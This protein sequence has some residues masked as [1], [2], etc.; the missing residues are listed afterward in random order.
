MNTDQSKDIHIAEIQREY[1]RIDRDWL[2]LHY[3]ISIGLVLFAF[4]VECFIGV[5]VVNSDMLSTSISTYL[6]K[7]LLA[8]SLINLLAIL[9]DSLVLRSQRFSQNQKIYTV[10]LMMVFICFILFS[11]HNAF[12]ATHMIFAVA[13]L[14]TVIYAD[15][16]L[17]G[18]TAASSILALV[19]SELF[20][21]WDLDKVSVFDST[22]RF[23]D[24]LVAIFVLFAAACVCLVEIH[25]ERKKNEASILKEIERQQLRLRLQRDEMTGVYNRK[26]LHDALRDMESDES[27]E[28]FVFVVVD[29]DNF[30]TINDRYGHLVGDRFLVEFVKTLRLYCADPSVFRYGGDEFCLF[31]RNESLDVVI[32]ICRNIQAKLNQIAFDDLPGATLLASFGIAVYSDQDNAARLFIHADQALYQAKKTRN[33]IHVFQPPDSG[34]QSAAVIP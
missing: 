14:L 7:F 32:E 25:Y 20:I 6:L 29:I 4:L 27:G 19:M 31:F 13:I 26:A 16:R 12:I 5:I 23:G 2:T 10:S 11:V 28:A 1:Q 3:K 9:A 34:S 21:T 33:S 18:V 17:T 15:F 8:P 22:L 24:F 30:K